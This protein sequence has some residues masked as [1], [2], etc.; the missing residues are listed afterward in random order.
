MFQLNTVRVL[1]VEDDAGD[2]RLVQIMLDEARLQDWGP[3]ISTTRVER[4]SEA[5]AALAS[6]TFDIVLLDL[7]LPDS[8]GLNTIT[9][10]LQQ[11]GST[12]IVIM[13]GLMDYT[14]S[15]EA[16][17][18]GAQDYLVKGHVDEY[19]L[20]RVI[21]FAIERKRLQEALQASQRLESIG[22]LVGGVSHDFNNLLT[23]ILTQN[24]LAQSQLPAEHPAAGHLLKS[25]QAALRVAEITRQL[26]AYVGK[27][28]YH[29]ER[30][31]IN[32]LLRG[33][34]ELVTGLIPPTVQVQFAPDAEAFFVRADRS[35]L[36]QVIVNLMTNAL[37]ALPA[38][39]GQVQISTSQR[40]LD[41]TNRASGK[42]MTGGQPAAGEY[43]C[44]AVAD[45][46][47]GMDATVLERIF[48]PFFTTKF[49]G[50]GM[51]LPAALGIVR[52]HHG[53]LQVQSQSGAGSV[54][55]VWLPAA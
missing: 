4:L 9:S 39:G 22:V 7:S 42:F 51:G 47:A 25:N 41:N 50:R 20:P 15:L 38:H 27:G 30:L 32:A 26:L 18:A 53:A 6:D 2:A 35:Q 3:A 11:A 54:F 8:S 5:L 24:Y 10:V 33:S 19:S 55:T 16:V 48:E 21:Q 28:R 36:Q 37:E 40:T 46:G 14:L 44:L 17:K 29:I 12:P 13:S 52:S 31:D 23:T 49:T 34:I 43:V 45:N 1:L